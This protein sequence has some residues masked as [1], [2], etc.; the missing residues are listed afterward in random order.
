MRSGSRAR[1]AGI[2]AVPSRKRRPRPHLAAGQGNKGAAELQKFPDRGVIIRNCS[3][4]AA[5]HLVVARAN[6]S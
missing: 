3:T 5:E 2:L 1:L 6:A 4:G